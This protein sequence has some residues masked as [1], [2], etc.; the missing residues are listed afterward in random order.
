MGRQIIKQPNGKY[1]VLS[2][3]VD[4]FVIIDATPE[5]I[6]DAWATEERERLR[7]RVGEIIGQLEVGAKP[8]HQFTMTFEEACAAV[9]AEHGPVCDSLIALDVAYDSDLSK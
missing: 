5:E 3:V 6:I 1:A 8:Y 7:K 2:S 4:D 9:Q